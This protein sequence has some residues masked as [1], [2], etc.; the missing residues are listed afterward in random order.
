MVPVFSHGKNASLFSG[1]YDNTQIFHKI[2]EAA[3]L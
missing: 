3:G 1:I 2:K